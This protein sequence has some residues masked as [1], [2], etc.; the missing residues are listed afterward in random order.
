[1]FFD[2]FTAG[3]VWDIAPQTIT[4]EQIKAFAAIYDPLPLHLDEDYARNTRYGSLIASGPMTFMTIWSE[5]IRTVDPFGD[6]LIGGI[7]NHASFLAP[8]RPSDTLTGMIRVLGSEVRNPYNGSVE[9]QL[10]GYNQDGLH[11]ITGGA[12]VVIARK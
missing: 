10:D 2:E 8:V 11:V 9:F 4:A 6:Q 1:L 7:G 5:F 3:K 12:L